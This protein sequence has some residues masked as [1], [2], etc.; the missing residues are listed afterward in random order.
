MYTAELAGASELVQQISPHIQLPRIL[1]QDHRIE[2]GIQRRPRQL[3]VS[4]VEGS[5]ETAAI[6]SFLS[7]CHMCPSSL[8]FIRLNLVVIKGNKDEIQ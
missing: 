5:Q 2:K 3:V 7:F 1:I 8:F 4:R 6:A